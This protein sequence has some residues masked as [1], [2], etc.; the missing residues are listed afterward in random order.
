MDSTGNPWRECL[1][2]LSRQINAFDSPDSSLERSKEFSQSMY[3]SHVWK[4]KEN[5]DDDW[6]RLASFEKVTKENHEL[7]D[8]RIDQ[9]QMH[10]ENLNISECALEEKFLQ[11]PQCS[12]SNDQTQAF[13]IQFAYAEDRWIM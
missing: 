12:I 5:N 2:N 9:L 13:I 3:R 4:I 10:T 1:K 6:S 8:D 11:Q 7:S